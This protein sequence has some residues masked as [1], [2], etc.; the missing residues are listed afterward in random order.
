MVTPCY[1][2]TIGGQ[3]GGAYVKRGEIQTRG[4]IGTRMKKD[5]GK[6]QGRKRRYVR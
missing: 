5:K 6:D 4:D 2:N 1:K 3:A